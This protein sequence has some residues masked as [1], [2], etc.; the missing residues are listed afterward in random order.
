MSWVYRVG[1][2]VGVNLPLGTFSRYMYSL[3][4]AFHVLFSSILL[5]FSYI[6]LWPRDLHMEPF[7]ISVSKHYVSHIPYRPGVRLSDP[8]LVSH[9]EVCWVS[10]LSS[11]LSELVWSNMAQVGIKTIFETLKACL[12][13]HG[14]LG[15]IL[16]TLSLLDLILD[17]YGFHWFSFFIE[18][19]FS[20]VPIPLNTIGQI[21]GGKHIIT[22]RHARQWDYL[23]GS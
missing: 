23:R 5:P 12:A 13:Q 14:P 10:G 3:S 15:V 20:S 16:V 17:R 6:Y 9:W 21:I 7:K 8:K 11:G 1:W 22:R 2:V 19:I 4:L 18:P